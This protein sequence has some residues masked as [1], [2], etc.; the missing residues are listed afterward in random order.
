[1]AAIEQWAG[2]PEKYAG[3]H[4]RVDTGPVGTN[5]KRLARISCQLKNWSAMMTG[6][7]LI[8]LSG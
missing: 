4:P 2:Y 1:V 8:A 3:S 6:A 7:E 5:A